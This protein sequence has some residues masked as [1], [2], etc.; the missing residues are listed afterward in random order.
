MG[1]APLT[2]QSEPGHSPWRMGE[3]T[4]DDT[5]YIV[6]NGEDDKTTFRLDSK[7]T[8]VLVQRYLRQCAA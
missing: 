3:G 5:A 7:K 2:F 4:G 6:H 1:D 8:C